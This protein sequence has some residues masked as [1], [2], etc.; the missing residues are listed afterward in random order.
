MFSTPNL[1]L[2][3]ALAAGTRHFRHPDVDAAAAGC[4]QGPAVE[5]P[6][7]ESAVDTAELAVGGSGGMMTHDMARSAPGYQHDLQAFSYGMLGAD[8]A[9]PP[10]VLA[11]A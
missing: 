11:C 4:L 10:P 9:S 6:S 3:C 1:A 5:P 8:R 7:H 2:Q